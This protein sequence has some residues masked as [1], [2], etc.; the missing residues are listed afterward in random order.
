MAGP[1]GGQQHD[2]ELEPFSGAILVQ[3]DRTSPMAP[4]LRCWAALCAPEGML[5]GKQHAISS[6]ASELSPVSPSWR[7][8]PNG[9]WLLGGQACN[10]A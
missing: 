7:P 5:I 3:L 2:G 4:Q 8:W 10:T 9:L 6:C 1:A